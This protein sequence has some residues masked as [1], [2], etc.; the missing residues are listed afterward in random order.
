VFRREK[1]L[2]AKRLPSH[3]KFLDEIMNQ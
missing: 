2:L 3:V 1:E